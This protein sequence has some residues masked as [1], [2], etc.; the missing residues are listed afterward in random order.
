MGHLTLRWRLAAVLVLAL[1]L[2]AGC[3]AEEA[4]PTT[5]AAA[6]ASPAPTVTLI[7]APP[8]ETPEPSMAPS[9]LP[10]V[11]LAPTSQPPT[12]PPAPVVDTPV[13]AAPVADA[14]VAAAQLN[15]R[16]G[17]GTGFDVLA[18]LAQDDP[19]E[20]IGQ[21]GSCAWLK[22]R[23]PQGVE[24][25]VAHV[26]GGKEYTTLNIACGS[27]AELTV[28]TPTARPATPTVQP[29]LPTAPP[30]ATRPAT[31]LVVNNAG[32]GMGELLVKNG[33]DSDALVIVATSDSRPL[34][35]AYIRAAESYN[36]AGIPDGAYWLYFCK[37]E[38]W[39]A[40]AKKFTRNETC[41][42]FEDPLGFQT[43]AT[44]YTGYEVTLYG[45]AGGTASTEQVDP[46]QVP[47]P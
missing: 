36:L 26:I 41:Q 3:P 42:R 14:V 19:L 47:R 13:A 33:T 40:A 21:S 17:P 32:G 29:A 43:T 20:V 2:L 10:T 6:P 34:M 11:T 4:Q 37:G 5:E 8:T 1:L 24:G 38:G 9:P 12:A 30:P 23:T 15:M 46:S 39:D 35:S 28:P 22:V 18:T 44:Q 16:S 31:G 7:P 45:V 27:V 25:W